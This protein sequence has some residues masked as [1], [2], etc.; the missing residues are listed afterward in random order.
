MIVIE[1]VVGGAYLLRKYERV[2]SSELMQPFI[3]R[4]FTPCPISPFSRNIFEVVPMILK[5]VVNSL[6]NDRVLFSSFLRFLENCEGVGGSRV[7]VV[8]EKLGQNL[9]HCRGLSGDC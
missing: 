8:V 2:G 7:V 4:R 5:R 3:D 1:V 9:S 6:A